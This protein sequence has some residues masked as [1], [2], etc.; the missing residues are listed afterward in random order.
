MPRLGSKRAPLILLALSAILPQLSDAAKKRHAH[1]AKARKGCQGT[2]IPASRAVR[3]LAK[4]FVSGKACA[5]G[6]VKLQQAA[7]GGWLG[8]GKTTASKSGAYSF[9]VELRDAAGASSVQLRAVT[10]DGSKALASVQ[11]SGQGTDSCSATPVPT[12]TAP[13]PTSQP[14]TTTPP[15]TTTPPPTDPPP[16][17][18]PPT[19]LPTGLKLLKEDLATDPDPMSLWGDI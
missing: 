8:L 14:P 18:P 4:L 7:G 12:S 6:M 17:T 5:K 13:P 3:P 11:L 9:C 15:R 10:S 1:S 19:D 2:V 16:T